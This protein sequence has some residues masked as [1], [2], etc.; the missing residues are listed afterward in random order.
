MPFLIHFAGNSPEVLRRASTHLGHIPRSPDK[1]WKNPFS[2]LRRTQSYKV[3]RGQHTHAT[4]V[5]ASGLQ[6]TSQSSGSLSSTSSGSRFELAAPLIEEEHGVPG[7]MEV[8]ARLSPT[9][10]DAHHNPS[11]EAAGSNREEQRGSLTVATPTSLTS[12]TDSIRTYGS[13]R[14]LVDVSTTADVSSTTTDS[15]TGNITSLRQELLSLPPIRHKQTC[16]SLDSEGLGSLA[17]EEIEEAGP[18]DW[19]QWSKEVSN[20]TCRGNSVIIE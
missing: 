3:A 6:G 19:T 2:N 18:Q 4:E 17:S 20:P 10:S 1:G 15:T 11:L 7:S 12:D 9:S 5:D 13:E 8:A 16:S 14:T